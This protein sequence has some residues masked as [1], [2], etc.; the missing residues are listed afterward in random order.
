MSQP[1][2]LYRPRAPKTHSTFRSRNKT[3]DWQLPPPAMFQLQEYTK[4]RLREH[5][6]HPERIRGPRKG[7]SAFEAWELQFT[8]YV[9]ARFYADDKEGE[10]GGLVWP[11]D[12]LMFVALWRVGFGGA[13]LT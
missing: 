5:V 3:Y 2:R 11:R 12:R 7:Q 1:R 6:D 10:G 8:E 9:G 13:A 4:Q